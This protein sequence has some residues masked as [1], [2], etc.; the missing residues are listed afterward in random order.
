MGGE[1][2]CLEWGE[3]VEMFVPRALQS[4]PTTAGGGVL[5][6]LCRAGDAQR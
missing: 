6:V 3:T 1:R 2:W 5:G 4:V